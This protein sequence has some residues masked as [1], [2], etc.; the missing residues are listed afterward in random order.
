MQRSLGNLTEGATSRGRPELKLV[1]YLRGRFLKNG[2]FPSKEMFVNF[3]A[4]ANRT[5]NQAKKLNAI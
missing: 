4:E 2:V 3:L 1:V 5:G